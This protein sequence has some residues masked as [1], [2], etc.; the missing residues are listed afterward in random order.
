[1]RGKVFS[2]L[3]S[4]VTLPR[5]YCLNKVGDCLVYRAV[6]L[7]S[8]AKSKLRGERALNFRQFSFRLSQEIRTSIHPCLNSV[9][10]RPLIEVGSLI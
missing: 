2:L 10:F 5:S 4:F 1:M 9:S 7:A 8:E 6:L 3:H